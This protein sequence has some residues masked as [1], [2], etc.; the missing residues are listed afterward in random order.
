MRLDL[1]NKIITASCLVLLSGAT[2]ANAAEPTQQLANDSSAIRPILAKLCFDCHGP[3]KQEGDVRLDT[4][5]ADVQDDAFDAT[6]WHDALDQIK[7]GEMPPAKAAQLSAE[8]RQQLVTWITSKLSEAEQHKR[9]ADG[10]V[11]MRRLT[12]YEYSN[13]VRDLLG[14]EF[15]FARDL[16]PEPASPDGFLN[17]GATLEMSST[18]IETYLATARRALELAIVEGDK[19]EVF[20][21]WATE[22]AV[23]KLPRRKEGGHIPVNPEFLLDIPQFPRSGEF[24]LLVRAGALVPAGQGVPRLRVSLGN[25]PGIIH[26]PR[27][28]VGEVDVTAPAHAP[29]VFQFRGRL[30]DFPQ[31]GDREFGANV[32]FNGMI[33]LIDFLDADGAE[34][35]YRDRTYSDPPPNKNSKAKPNAKSPP[36][37]GREAPQQG[38]RYNI[39]IDSVEFEAPYFKSWPPPSHHRLMSHSVQATT[40][41]QKAGEI[42]QRFMQLAFRRPVRDDELNQTMLLFTSIRPMT[43]SFAAAIRETLASVLVSPHFLYIVEQRGGGDETQSGEENA[44][45]S[46]LTEFE[47]ATRLSYFLWSTMP[48]ERL[49]E[50]AASG[51]LSDRDVLDREV[52]RMM[53]DPSCNEFVNHFADQWFDLQALDRV[54]VNPEFYPDFDNHLKAAMREETRGFLREILVHDRSCLELLQADWTVANR[55][56]A[57]HYGLADVP[58]TSQFQ[59]VSLRPQDRRGGILT[60]GAFLLSRSDGQRPHP[61]RRAVWILDR[62][63]DSPPASPPADVPD[64]D[65]DAADSASLT[66]KQQLEVHRQKESCRSCHEGIDPWGIPLEHFDAV[67]VWREKSPVRV[68]DAKKNK[69]N[70]ESTAPA[71]DAAAVLP[72]G[73]QVDGADDLKSYLSEQQRE[74]FARS[75]VKRLAAYALGRS[76]DLGDRVAIDSLTSEF[77]ANEFRLRH[78]IL[79]LVQSDLFHTK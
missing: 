50:L 17:N 11:L 66:L 69:A 31:P 20:R 78:L 33:A 70:A 30:E 3:K 38:P 14:I 16:P 72:S 6:T 5:S 52:Q 8:Q 28:L 37:G 67:G 15:D 76:L 42:L 32:D 71:V 65:A 56:L 10:R 55:M 64:L 77:I 46:R 24:R 7:L 27:K 63:L 74:L 53:D 54:A 21:Y 68:S 45:P 12:R 4:L 73:D 29:Q 75:V 60:Q 39:V 25:V 34:L 18:Q 49:R 47:L 2:P 22:T 61:I 79:S 26:V 43:D 51:Q 1:L 40:D 9:F 19:P 44:T 41:E 35:R 62:L 13:T 58:D 59:R 48:D 23:G 57:R 36:R